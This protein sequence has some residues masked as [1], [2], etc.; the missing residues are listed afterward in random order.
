MEEKNYVKKR[1]KALD[2]LRIKKLLLLPIISGF[3]Q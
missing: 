2:V 1:K 3:N